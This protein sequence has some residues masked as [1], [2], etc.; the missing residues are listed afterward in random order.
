MQLNDTSLLRTDAY[1][2]G[3]W[4]S[5]GRRHA[6]IDPATGEPVA[7]VACLGEQ[8]VEQAIE[9]AASGLITWQRLSA[10]QRSRV[11]L[12]LA[13]LMAEH[14]RDLAQLITIEQGKPLAESLGE[15]RYAAGFIEWFSGEA[16]RIQ[17]LTIAPHR[18]DSRLTVLRQ[19]VGVCA[20]I[21]PWNFPCAMVTRKLGAALAAGCVLLVKPAE[22]TPLSALALAELS[23]RAG[24]PPGGYSVL[25]GNREDAARIGRQLCA[26][27]TVRK[28]SFTGSTAVGKALAAQCAGTVKRLSLELGGNAPFMVFDDADLDAAVAGAMLCKFR[29]CGQTCVS[30]NRFLVQRHVLTEFT[31]R[32]VDQ[33]S[34]LRLGPGSTPGTELGPLIDERAL[35]KTDAHVN[36]ALRRGAKLEIG[37]QRSTLGVQRSSPGGHFYLPTVVSGVTPSMQIFREE[38][39]GPVA[40]ITQF[41]TDEDAL[42]LANQ[43]RAGLAAYLYT[44][45]LSRSNYF[46][47]A[48]EYGM[49]GLNTGMIST[50]V[51][52]FGGIKESG[53][54]REGSSL[55]L[56]DYL[57][58]KYLCQGGLASTPAD[59]K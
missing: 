35:E 7:S 49:V 31:R 47:E 4:L 13:D 37:G 19:P 43:T 28:L 53:F 26:S 23:E 44:Q 9:A 36:D 8:E 32:L 33:V 20:G 59:S 24:L 30:A 29:N 25:T 56:D 51:A 5:T 34:R 42:Q 15:V 21:T 6:V 41:D 10:L 22:A 27:E 1:V 46:G 39:F 40:P 16:R 50:E 57:Q 58:Y 12:R 45:S 14:E 52:P 11:L 38:T 48:L 55:G 17:G 18:S 3:R 54:G 2:A